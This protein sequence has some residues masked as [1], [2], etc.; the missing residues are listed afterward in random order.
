MAYQQVSS[1]DTTTVPFLRIGGFHRKLDREIRSV[2]KKEIR[3]Q[4]FVLGR[5]VQAFESQWA[6]FC[7]AKYAV[8]VGSGLSAIE[9]SLRALGVG[10]GDEVL[11]PANT[12]IA[13]WMA[14]SNVRAI[15]VP[16]PT[17]RADYNLSPELLRSR[18]SSKTRAIIPVHLYGHPADLGQ[19]QEIAAVHNLK[20]VEDAAQAHGAEY[21]GQRIGAHSDAVAWSFYPGKNLGAFGDGGAVTTNSLDM[22]D[23]IRLLSNYGSGEKYHHDIVGTNSRLD[24]LQAAILTAKLKY[25][26]EFN[27]RRKSIADA[28]IDELKPLAEAGRAI[29]LPPSDSEARLSAWHLF[30]I[31][32]ENRD[33]VRTFLQARGIETGIHYPIPPGNQKAYAPQYSKSVDAASI[34]DA[35]E[36]LS[37]PIGPHLSDS[38]VQQVCNA[39]GQA[40]L[41]NGSR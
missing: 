4:D 41:R 6:S 31:R 14:V 39:I 5:S 12:F 23:K 18:I 1:K 19:I 11:V 34:K 9:V 3:H 17:S 15:P 29:V 35:G 10:E 24:S 25:L 33:M 38:Q 26:E 7:G 13:T 30:V 37:L 40:F 22:A 16:V 2:L 21:N 20:V 27:S 36:L 8:G 28:Y 32:V